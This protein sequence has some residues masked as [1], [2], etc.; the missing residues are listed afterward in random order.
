MAICSYALQHAKLKICSFMLYTPN[1][2]DMQSTYP[3]SF[4]YS[5][6]V[7]APHQDNRQV[8][9]PPESRP[10]PQP[11]S[12]H[13]TLPSKSSSVRGISGIVKI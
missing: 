8:H 7:P 6:L 1:V 9:S 4:T 11:P 3:P 5:H 13:P 2:L 10:A 12:I